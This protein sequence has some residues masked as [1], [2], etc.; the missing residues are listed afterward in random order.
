MI[1]VKLDA[2]D[3]TNTYLKQLSK[4][5][6]TKNWTVVTTEFQTLGRGQMQTEWLS[7]KGKNLT[8]SVL[9]RFDDFKASNQFYLNYA[10]S[11]GIFNALKSYDLPQ[12]K[13]KWPN[14]ILSA[15]K[16]VVGILI[17][18]SLKSDNIYQTIIGIG[19]NVNQDNFP[20]TLPKAIS[21]KQI[22]KRDFNRDEILIKIVDSIKTQVAILNQGKFELLYQNYEKALFKK[23]QVQMFENINQQ[24]FM[25]KIIGVSKEGKLCVEL[26]DEQIKEFGFKEVKF[27]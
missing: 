23:D 27:L 17:E 15:S 11:L 25:G 8:L 12:L 16:K 4:N 3:S 1:L 9:I 2:I 7:D 19:L 20:K 21:M 24:K 6:D 18:N 26:E 5:A 14:D 13:I 22:L 10:I